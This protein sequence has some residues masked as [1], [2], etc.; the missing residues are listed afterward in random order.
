MALNWTYRNGHIG[1]DISICQ[2]CFL[3]KD[4]SIFRYVQFRAM[5][6]GHIG[7]DISIGHI[8]LPLLFH[9]KRT[10]RYFH[11][12]M[13]ILEPKLLDISEWTNRFGLYSGLTY[14]SLSYS[15]MSIYDISIF[16]AL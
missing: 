11:Y 12:D 7:M 10:Y 14:T 1:M 5:K 16:M 8:D 6:I 13:S 2:S 4:I 9:T 15:D 3:I